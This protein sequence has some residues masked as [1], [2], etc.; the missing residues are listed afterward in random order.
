MQLIGLDWCMPLYGYGDAPSV[1]PKDKRG[2]NNQFTARL[3]CPQQRLE[4][5]STLR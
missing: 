3:M 4:D 1:L 5:F 2:W